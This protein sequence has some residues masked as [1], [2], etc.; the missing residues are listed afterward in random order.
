MTQE[1]VD[2][3]RRASLLV[4]D[5]RLMAEVTESLRPMDRARLRQAQCDLLSVRSHVAAPVFLDQDDVG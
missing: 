3:L 1:L 2:M 5:I 4:A